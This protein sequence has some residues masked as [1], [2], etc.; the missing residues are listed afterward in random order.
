MSAEIKLTAIFYIRPV[1]YCKD[2]SIFFC[3]LTLNML[4]FNNSGKPKT[5]FDLHRLSK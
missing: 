1:P 4:Q 5:C 2:L 3:V